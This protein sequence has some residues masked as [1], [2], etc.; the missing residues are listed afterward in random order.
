MVQAD[1]IIQIT[2]RRLRS[3]DG[4]LGRFRWILMIHPKRPNSVL[5]YELG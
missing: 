1:P 2:N 5:K 3:D 4:R